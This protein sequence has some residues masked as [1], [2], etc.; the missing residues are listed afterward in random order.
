MLALL[1]HERWDGS[2]YPFGLVGEAIPLEARIVAVVDTYDALASERPYK[3]AF[4]EEKCLAII[5]ESS[6]GHFDPR[7]VE[8][9]FKNTDNIRSI[10]I[11]WS[12]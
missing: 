3:K 5:R 10:R 9:F 12:D 7:V 11:K 8:A 6:G 4:P 2:G 1:H